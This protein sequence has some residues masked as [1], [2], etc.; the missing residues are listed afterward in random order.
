MTLRITAGDQP[1]SNPEP[2]W[3]QNINGIPRQLLSLQYKCVKD[4]RLSPDPLFKKKHLS[5]FGTEN[6][7]F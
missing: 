7:N 2:R 1:R 6:P 4:S 5:P 3:V